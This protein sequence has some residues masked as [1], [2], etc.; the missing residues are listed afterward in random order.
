VSKLQRFRQDNRINKIVS[1]LQRF[2]QD[3]RINKIVCK[4]QF[5]SYGRSFTLR[6]TS[7]F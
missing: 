2:R 3:N 4:L 1:K 5:K 7:V 6:L